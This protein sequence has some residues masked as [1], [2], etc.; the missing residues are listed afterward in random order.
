MTGPPEPR[1]DAR[2]SAAL[3]LGTV[4]IGWSAIFVKLAGVPGIASAFYRLFFAGLI[5]V[6]WYLRARSTPLDRR[7]LALAS[8]GGVFFALDLALWNAAVLRS[9][10]ARATLLANLAPLW[11][12]LGA[13]AL[14]GERLSGRFWLGMALAMGGM[15]VIVGDDLGGGIQ[16]GDAMALGASFFYAAYLLAT[17]RVRLHMDTVTFMGLS[18]MAAILLLGILG[19]LLDV[20]MRAY[21]TE[22]WLHLLGLGLISH[23]G[24]WLAINFA[25]GHMPAAV[26][27]VTLLGQPVLTALFAIPVLGE[28]PSSAEVAGGILVLIGIA[29]VHRARMQAAERAAAAAPA[30]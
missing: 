7:G 4:C 16:T 18:T 26:V 30:A 11:V 6:P 21:P 10:A 29:T 2:A 24:G 20:P 3:A 14:F 22:A 19:F 17:Q 8:L 5:I 23:L 25:L 28:R 12:G 15:A 13:V 1:P 27:S 9:S